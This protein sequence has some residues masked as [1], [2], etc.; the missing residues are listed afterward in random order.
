MR[1]AGYLRCRCARDLGY[2]AVVYLLKGGS[3]A[4]VTIQGGEFT[5]IRLRMR[6]IRAARAGVVLWT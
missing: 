4:L 6:S 3:G 2:A 5:P 1:A